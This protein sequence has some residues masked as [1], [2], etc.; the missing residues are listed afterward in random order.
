MM[1]GHRGRHEK[2]GKTVDKGQD[3]NLKE[4]GHS[5]IL[6]LPQNRIA[7]DPDAASDPSHMPL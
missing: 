4:G 5:D 1:T 7:V 2:L 6:P 3:H